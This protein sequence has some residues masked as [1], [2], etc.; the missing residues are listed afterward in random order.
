FFLTLPVAAALSG[1]VALVVGWLAFRLRSLRGEIFALLTLAVPFIIAPI[2]RI[3]PWIDGGQGVQ[4]PVPA[5][6]RLVG[7]FQP[8]L[9]L[10]SGAIALLAVGV[11]YAIQHSRMGWGLFAIRD[12]EP[13]AE[14]LG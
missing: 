11:A 5:E 7:G 9:F 6:A 8:F 4:V 10:V 1:G 2:I 13:V 3:T 12:A 14:G